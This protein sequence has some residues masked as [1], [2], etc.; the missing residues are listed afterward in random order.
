MEK[1]LHHLFFTAAKRAAL[2]V[3]MRFSFNAPYYSLPKRLYSAVELVLGGILLLIVGSGL[4]ALMAS[5][6]HWAVAYGFYACISLLTLVFWPHGQLGWANRVTLA[7]AALVAVVAGGLVGDAFI[8]ALWQWLAIAVIALALDG[9]DGWIARRTQSHSAFGA[10]FDMELDALLIMLLCVG[11]LKLA[12]T[13]GAWV[14][15]IGGIRYLFVAASWLLPW[16]GKPLFASFRRKAVCVWQV[17]A[18]LLALTPL[19]SSLAASLFALSALITLVYS[20]GFDVWWLYKQRSVD[21]STTNQLT[22]RNKPKATHDHLS[23]P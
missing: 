8:V 2:W 6:A 1:Q 11:L 13:I 3:A 20:F 18:L 5:P 12:P 4:P 22:Q 15:I 9:L 23:P 17:V 7:R 10:R 21:I 14:L 19:T 16:L